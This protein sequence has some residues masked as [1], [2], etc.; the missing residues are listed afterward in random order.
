[1]KTF[2]VEP[3]T[4]IIAVKY[5]RE[6]KSFSPVNHTTTKRFKTSHLLFDS[7]TVAEHKAEFQQLPVVGKELGKLFYDHVNK[8]MAILMTSDINFPY[9]MV[10]ERFITVVNE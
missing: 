1:M 10:E 8:G 6:N 3:G 4:E 7:I 5:T 2:I 9:M